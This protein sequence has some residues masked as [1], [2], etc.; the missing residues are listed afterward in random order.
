LTHSHVPGWT[1]LR[2]QLCRVAE[3]WDL[4]GTP[5]FQHYRGVEGRARSPGIR[6]GRRTRRSSLNLHPR[7]NHKRVSSH[8]GHPWVLGQATGTSTHKTH[9]GPDSREAATFPHIVFS[10]TLCGGYIQMA[11]FPGTPKLESRN[12]P[13]TVPVGVPGLWKLV[14]PDCRVWSW[15]GLNQ[16][17]SPRRDLSN[18]VLHSQF[19]GR[20]E[21]DSRLL[22]VGSQIGSLTPGLSFAHNL[23]CRCPNG[24]CEA[25][26][27][28]YASRSFQWNQE[29]PNARCFG[30]CCRT[31]NI[32]KSRRTP[33]SQLWEW[34]FHP[35]TSPKVGL[36]QS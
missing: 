8:S 20:E 26:F 4:K 15:Q 17:C 6:L 13:E 23:S 2:V 12:C 31:L 34:E 5:N 33:N 21:V 27:D 28:I 30:L 16:S 36:R 32:R 18:A 22:V 11:L 24:Q 14:T 1:H 9:H 7:T 10:T 19:G 25:I 29:H 3:S 35:P